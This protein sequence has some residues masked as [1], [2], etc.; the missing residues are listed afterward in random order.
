MPDSAPDPLRDLF[1]RELDSLAAEASAT[2]ATIS[3][4]RIK[5]LNGLAK[6]L[7]TRDSLQPK[8]RN[9]APALLLIA[10]L[11]IAS[12]LLFAHVRETEI[13][14]DASLT[15]LS[16]T[17]TKAQA[18]TGAVDLA[19]LGVSGLRELQLPQSP[20]Y[21][22]PVISLSAATANLRH[23]VVTLSPLLVPAAAQIDLAC[24]DVANQ[25]R[26]SITAPNLVLTPAAFGPVNIS[27]PG[28]PSR[29]LDFTIPK[30]ILLRGGPADVGLDLTFAALPQTPISPQLKVRQVSFS[31][32]DQFLQPDQTIVK[33]LST[34]LSGTLSFESLNGEELRLRPGEELRFEQS[35]GEIRSVALAANHI[36]FTFHGRV[37]GMTA[38]T[39]EGHRSIMP[40]YLDW[41]KARHGLS[42]LWGTAFY[43]FG[44]AAAALRWFGVR[45]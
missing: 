14:I 41:L 22:A 33:R 28:S 38:G 17:L 18:L 27:V 6:L 24:S 2:D 36:D 29:A 44:I 34:I 1:R 40:T 20:P 16:F 10:T 32:I 21:L 5:T 31:R 45:L 13:E 11:T 19:S 9:W 25:Y 42:L 12:V 26:L 7:E 4:A 8:P 23:G 35:E 39:G 37:R 3:P 15:Q 30:P 43:L